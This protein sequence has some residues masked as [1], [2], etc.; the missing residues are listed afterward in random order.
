MVEGWLL[1]CYP[2]KDS[3]SSGMTFWLKQLASGKTLKLKDS[4]WHASIYASG[5][6]CD[7][8]SYVSSK[9]ENS[10]LVHSI[11]LVRRRINAFTKAKS[12]VLQFE[13]SNA[14]RARS[15]AERLEGA[16]QG[17]D[18]IH[19]YNVDV[20]PEQQYFYEKDLFPLARVR[21]RAQGGEVK[22]WQLLDDSVESLNYEVPVLRCVRLDAKLQDRVPGLDSKLNSISLEAFTTEGESKSAA[23]GNTDVITLESSDEAEILAGSMKEIDRF[24]PDLLITRNGDSFVI[25]YLRSKA[26]K[27]GVSLQKLDRDA[28]V[29]NSLTASSSVRAGKTYFSYGRIL[30]RPATQRL[31]GR[32][33]LDEENTFVYDQCRLQGLFEVSRLCRMPMHT[34]MRASIGKCLSGLQFYNAFKQ[35]L[36]IPWKPEITEDGKNGYELFK[37]DRGGLV[38]NPLPGIHEHIFEIDFASLYPSII[39][40]YNISAETVNCACCRSGSRHQIEELGMHICEK[41]K[42]I[43]A[44]SLELPLEK[45]FAYKRL[46]DSTQDRW[47]KSVYNERAGAL[48]WIL[49]CC[50]ARESPVLIQQKDGL[51]QYVKIGDFIDNIVS[52]K[53]GIIDCPD[54]ISVASVDRNLKVKFCKVKKLLKVPNNQKLLDITLDDGRK[55]TATPN[56]PFYLL[57]NG[58]LEVRQASD[59]QEGNFIPVAKKLPSPP[60]SPCHNEGFIDVIDQLTRKLDQVELGRW[61]VSG[62]ILSQMILENKL[63]ILEASMKEGYSNQAVRVWAKNGFIPL[64]F[65]HLLNVPRE[66]HGSLRV[67]IGRPKGKFGITSWM[68]AVI[69]TNEE[70]GFFLGLYIADGSTTNTYIRLDIGYFETDLL[71]NACMVTKSLFRTTPRVYKENGVNM[72]IVQINNL[73][74]V[75]FLELVLGIPPTPETGKLKAPEIVFNSNTNVAQGF[76]EGVLA[77][78]GSI[79]KKRSFASVATSSRDF[80][81]QIGYIGATLG[82]G[83]RIAIHPRTLASPMYTVNFVGPETLK[84]VSQWKYLKKAHRAVLDPKLENLCDSEN[85]NCTHPTYQL[86][87]TTESNIVLLAREARTVRTPRIDQR[88][89]ACPYRITQIIERISAFSSSKRRLGEKSIAALTNVIRM[90]QGDLGFARIRKIEELSRVDDYVYCFQLADDEVPGFFTGEGAVFTHNCFGYLS[91]RNAKFGKIDSH[92]A[93]CAQARKTLLDA[94]HTAEYH[95]FRMIHGIVDSLWIAK[96]GADMEDCKELCKEIEAQTGFKLAIE[97]Q[98]RWIVFLPSKTHSENQVANRY[99]GRFEDKNEGKVRGIELRRR[100]TPPYFKKCQGEILQALYRCDDVSEL[101]QAART[102][103]VRIFEKYAEALEDHMV[104]PSELLIRRRLSKNLDEYFSKRQLPVSA[105][106]KLSIRGLELQAGQSISYVITRYRTSGKDRSI[107]EEI[108]TEDSEYDSERYVELL[109]DCCATVLSPFGVTKERLL[110][111]AE[112]TLA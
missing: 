52:G 50:L 13:L 95:G 16:F 70:L 46:R 67:G 29:S 103:G 73:A 76:L 37:S 99:F 31:F 28:E 32:L 40:N 66:L 57:K 105:A 12:P 106:S 17:Y 107:P 22:S 35:G 79:N 55:V 45:R 11:N 30:Y 47:L 68:P 10:G 89:S 25:P 56:H 4:S 109:S 74:I 2:S 38:F 59:L 104:P 39:R 34:S 78:D 60:S 83:F 90:F 18:A 111:R 84:T 65:F 108:V 3:S 96:D 51:V 33:H 86:F 80:A 58:N 82:L 21:A 5:E 92:I 71:E 93:V 54:G 42:G 36:L 43:V 97:G 49:V 85:V 88:E 69:S 19:L 20:L 41:R 72:Y 15:L 64:R 26:A 53:E 63:V 112:S 62:A 27:C 87:P 1:D 81:N 110:T 6:A 44:S 77:G 48:K 101:R 61:R 102:D 9:V 98:Y 94:L 23:E 14:G 100:D 24:D 7:N 8:P 91:Y 75:K